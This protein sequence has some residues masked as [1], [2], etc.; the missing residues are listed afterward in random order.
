MPTYVCEAITHTPTYV[1][2]A[3]HANMN[4][5]VHFTRLNKLSCILQ[6][7]FS[8]RIGVHSGDVLAAVLGNVMP[9]YFIFGKDFETASVLESTGKTGHIHVSEATAALIPEG[10]GL[11]LRETPLELPSG[12]ERW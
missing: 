3:L 9:R 7:P 6:M 8:V 5:F 12:S 11:E 10:W 2:E 4:D 1:S